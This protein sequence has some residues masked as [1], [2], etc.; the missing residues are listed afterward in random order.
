[1]GAKQRLSSRPSSGARES[2]ASERTAPPPDLD[3]VVIEKTLNDPFVRTSLQETL[4]R[5]GRIDSSS[6]AGQLTLCRFN[7]SIGHFK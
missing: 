5:I 7:H 1:M 2:F 4:E 3:D 6:L